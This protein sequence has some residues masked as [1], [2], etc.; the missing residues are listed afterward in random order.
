LRPARRPRLSPGKGGATT[1]PLRGAVFVAP[2]PHP[3]RQGGSLLSPGIAH[4][5]FQ[6]GGLFLPARNP[7]DRRNLI[8]DITARARSTGL[9]QVLVDGERWMVRALGQHPVRCGSCGNTPDSACYSAAD[10]RAAY[11][12]TCVFAGDT[13]E[14][15]R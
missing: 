14:A 13:Q 4:V 1:A 9:V 11:C 8:E 10:E 12:A 15:H 2:P 6:G 5:S 3:P 7:S